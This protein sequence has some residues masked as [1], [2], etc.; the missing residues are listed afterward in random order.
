MVSQ[1]PA[2]IIIDQLGGQRFAAATGATFVRS[3]YCLFVKF[4]RSKSLNYMTVEYNKRADL[5]N[6]VFGYVDVKRGQRP[7]TSYNNVSSNDL[8]ELF[9][10][11]TGLRTRF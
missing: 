5:Y 6:V 1:S 9:E 2:E 8:V 10:Q 11:R 4:K 7:F 3:G